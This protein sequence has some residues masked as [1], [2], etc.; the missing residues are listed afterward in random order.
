[1]DLFYAFPAPRNRKQ[2]HPSQKLLLIF[3]R[4]PAE[5]RLKFWLPPH[6]L[7]EQCGL[8]LLMKIC[9][10]QTLKFYRR[11]LIGSFGG[12]KRSFRFKAENAGHNIIWKAPYRGVIILNSF[13]VGTAFYRNTVFCSL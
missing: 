11:C 5:S 10:Y 9:P 4:L 3:Y 8:V 6:L 1:G 13:I 7:R 2:P 12:L